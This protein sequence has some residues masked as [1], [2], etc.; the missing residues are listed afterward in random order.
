MVE[1]PEVILTAKQAVTSVAPAGKL[2]L[3]RENEPVLILPG[4]NAGFPWNTLRVELETL[5]ASSAVGSNTRSMSVAPIVM[6]LPVVTSTQTSGKHVPDPTQFPDAQSLFA[7][8]LLPSSAPPTHCWTQSES[9]VQ[10]VLGLLLHRRGVPEPTTTPCTASV[11]STAETTAR[12]RSG[13]EKSV[14]AVITRDT[15]NLV[16]RIF[17]Y[18]FLA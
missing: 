15:L 7:R 2:S 14:N 6:L 1:H 11:V 13:A 18:L 4:A 10:A 12:V 8:Q 9:A 5:I 3:A 16:V 17:Y